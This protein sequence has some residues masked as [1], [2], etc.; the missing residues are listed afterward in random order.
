MCWGRYIWLRV[1]EK[2]DV[3]V[4]EEDLVVDVSVCVCVFLA[5]IPMP[6]S[7]LD[8]DG[9]VDESPVLPQTLVRI[10]IQHA[11]A[12]QKEAEA[13]AAAACE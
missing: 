4:S 3:G 7:E 6:K 13:V 8:G 9:G 11:E 2:R 12:V 10:P 5:K 1:S